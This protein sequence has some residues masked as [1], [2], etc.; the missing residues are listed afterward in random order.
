ML[1]LSREEDGDED[2]LDGTLY[3]NGRYQTQH[4]M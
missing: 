3:G 2:L 4:G 1:K